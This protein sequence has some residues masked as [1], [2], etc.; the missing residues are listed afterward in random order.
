MTPHRDI[1]LVAKWVAIAFFYGRF[2]GLYVVMR[3]FNYLAI[4]N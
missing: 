1:L 4:D 3:F 2:L